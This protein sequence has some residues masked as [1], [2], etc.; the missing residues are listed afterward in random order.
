MATQSD[1]RRIA[2]LLP[3][4]EEETGRF[5]FAVPVKGKMK[6][7]A[8]SWLERLDPK[9]A[10]VPSTAVLALRVSSLAQKDLMIQA[11]PDKFFTEPHYNGYPAVLLRLSAVRAPELRTLLQD[12]WQCCVPGAQAKGPRGSVKPAAK[13]ASRASDAAVKTR[14]KTAAKKA[15]PKRA[16]KG[17]R[18]PA[19][20][21]DA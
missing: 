12:A 14:A 8:W 10:R 21:R 6:G 17:A 16:A 3:G 20:N 7:Y 9:K 15:A 13:R 4:T 18:A 11:E 19:R 5:A 2:M 1:V